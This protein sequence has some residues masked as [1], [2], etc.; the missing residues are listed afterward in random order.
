MGVYEETGEGP[1]AFESAHQRRYLEHGA[2]VGRH[3]Q[4][5][6]EVQ[7]FDALD[8]VELT[9]FAIEETARA[10]SQIAAAVGETRVRDFVESRQ[11]STAQ[12]EFG[13]DV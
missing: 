9:C 2:Q 5:A 7:K 12:L 13:N 10:E 6:T 8:G 11:L 3:A 1:I 4:I